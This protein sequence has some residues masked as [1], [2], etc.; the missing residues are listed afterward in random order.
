MPFRGITL[1]LHFGGKGCGITNK[2]LLIVWRYDT[3]QSRGGGKHINIKNTKEASFWEKVREGE[4]LIESQDVWQMYYRK[5]MPK[6]RKPEHDMWENLFSNKL[7]RN[8]S[9]KTFGSMLCLDSWPYKDVFFGWIEREEGGRVVEEKKRGKEEGIAMKFI[10]T[11]CVCVCVQHLVSRILILCRRFLFIP[12]FFILTSANFINWVCSLMYTNTYAYANI[13]YENEE[14]SSIEYI[15]CECIINTW[16]R[17]LE[18]I[19]FW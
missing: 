7:Y 3:H 14:I 1:P 2:S 17:S 10:E 15:Y 9:N 4:I 12:L 19:G 8:V 16:W 6:C 5:S 18:I 13:P 11:A